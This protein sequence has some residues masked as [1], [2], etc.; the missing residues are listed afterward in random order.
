MQLVVGGETGTMRVYSLNGKKLYDLSGT[1]SCISIVCSATGDLILGAFR[2]GVIRS[3][4]GM[5]NE[6]AGDVN[7]QF[8]HEGKVLGVFG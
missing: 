6:K 4:S 7:G 8:T 2:D 5:G 3:Y 1:G